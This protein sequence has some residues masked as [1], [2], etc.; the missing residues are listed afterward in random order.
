MMKT[1]TP[2]GVLVYRPG[3]YAFTLEVGMGYR[4]IWHAD[5]LP[6][7][8]FQLMLDVIAWNMLKMPPPGVGI[9]VPPND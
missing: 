8:A 2:N 3:F 9:G 5:I 7:G 6:G 4:L 1:P